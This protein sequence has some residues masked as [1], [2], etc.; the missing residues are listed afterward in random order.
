MKKNKEFSF[1]SSTFL[2]LEFDS[3]SVS[4]SFPAAPAF[5]CHK[6]KHNYFFVMSFLASHPNFTISF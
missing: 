5:D 6:G 4:S 2:S 3:V 1:R